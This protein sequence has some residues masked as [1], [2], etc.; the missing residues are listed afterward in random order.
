M[1]K[2]FKP[3]LT[4][5]E[6]ILLLDNLSKML[7]AGVSMHESLVV[8]QEE[9]NRKQFKSILEKIINEAND[10]IPLWKT[11]DRHNAL[12]SNGLSLVRIGEQ[13]GRLV[14]N[15]KLLTEQQEK[16]RV[17]NQKI[18]SALTYPIFVLGLTAIVGSLITWFVLP[19]LTNIFST[20]QADLPFITRVLIQLG[21]I[22][23]EDGI[24]IVPSTIILL[25]LILYFLFAFK[26]TRQIGQSILQG[27]PGLQKLIRTVELARF[28][29]L[30]GTLIDSGIPITE[31]FVSLENST[32][33][34]NYKK[35]YKH[36]RE[37]VSEGINFQN[38]FHKNKDIEKIISRTNQQMIIAA[39]RSGNLSST[40]VEISKR[41]EGETENVLKNITVLMEPIMLVVVWL[42]VVGVA[43]AVILPIYQL[44]SVIN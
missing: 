16:N 33:L 36:A 32:E 34:K 44:V 35:F 41:A 13:S 39:E 4:T 29:Y 26:H 6:R 3:R 42:G 20:L 17:F 9:A 14:E 28:G 10:G 18:R 21:N 37:K 11:F 27:T 31:A 15:L 23:K 12:S 24:I 30:L 43:L 40:L 2:I 19:R 22:L 7:G 5:K 8:I 1:K 38:I 25:G